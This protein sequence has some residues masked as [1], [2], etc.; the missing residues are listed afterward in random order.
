MAIY[1]RSGKSF[2]SVRHNSNGE[3]LSWPDFMLRLDIFSN[4]D[5]Q[6]LNIK[7]NKARYIKTWRCQPWFTAVSKDF[8]TKRVW[9]EV[10]IIFSLKLLWPCI[11]EFF[12]YPYTNLI[13]VNVFL[14]RVETSVLIFERRNIANYSLQYA[15]FL[16][17]VCTS[18]SSVDVLL[19]PHN[20]KSIQPFCLSI[21]QLKFRAKSVSCCGHNY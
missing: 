20:C 9:S 21:C 16:D 5:S 4:P 15:I 2:S 7:Q 3:V 6:V 17:N 19:S 1:C 11:T 12:Y 10:T 18:S 14:S 13:W 8:L